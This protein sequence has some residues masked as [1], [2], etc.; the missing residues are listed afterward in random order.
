MKSLP[1]VFAGFIFFCAALNT[2]SIH[3]LTVDEIKRLKEAGVEDRTI[4]MF[5]ELE[6][7]NRM[8][9]EGVGVIEMSRS[10]GGK[11]RVYY[12]GA[13]PEEENNIRE[14]EKEKMERA[15]EILRNMVIEYR[16]K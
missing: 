16:R 9:A 2:I 12:S 1:W 5:I 4:R 8:G 7:R 11:E 3:A 10:D 6:R 14:E 15:L 13:T